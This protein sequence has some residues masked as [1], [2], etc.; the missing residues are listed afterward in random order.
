MQG[1]L[2]TRRQGRRAPNKRTTRPRSSA[3][4]KSQ[5]LPPGPGRRPNAP[6]RRT[7]KRGLR[8]AI[9]VALGGEKISAAVA[10]TSPG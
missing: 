5:A 8:S 9:A 10:R 1:G 4:S 3:P 7:P 2:P 6:A